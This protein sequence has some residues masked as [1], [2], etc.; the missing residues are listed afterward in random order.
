MLTTRR[1]AVA[2]LGVL[3][4]GVVTAVSLAP[5]DPGDQPLPAPPSQ[6]PDP[7]DKPFRAFVADSWW[8]T[9]LPRDAP[10]NPDGS[11]IL[12]YMST[13]DES[14]AGCLRLA[15]A[16]DSQWGQPIYWSTPSDTS[17]DVQG[18]ESADRPRE[19]DGLR[20]PVGAEAGENNDGNM[21][22]FDRNRG[23]V[24]AL[25]DA[26]Y[27][28]S[29]DEWSA[30]GGSVTYL[31][32]NGLH[33]STGLSDESRNTGS[34]RGNNGAT[35]AVRR[36]MVVAGEI[37]HVL[38]AA[39]GPE[40]AERYVFPM[41]G[42]DGSYDGD[43]PEV[44]PQGLRLRIKPSVDLDALNLHPEAQVIAEALQRYG[45]Y[46]GDSGGSTALKLQNTVAEGRGQLWGV[47]PDDLCR[48]PFTPEYWD[49]VAEGYDP[50][51]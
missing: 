26:E 23:Y 10:Q 34:H 35:M 32:S 12:D 16:N 4:L 46:I 45:F 51:Q 41:V 13:A 18:T 31:D 15:G 44:P 28:D 36:D 7:T 50:S 38:K 22:I 6:P 27:D 37:N 40:V 21:T 20:I 5:G 33:A 1:S 2:A 3:A 24:V 19:L 25:T 30:T 29:E 17:Y 8:N 39:L 47:T 42:S 48:L 9:P 11:E 49:V 14:G 43:D